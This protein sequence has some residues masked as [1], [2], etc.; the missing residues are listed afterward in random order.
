MAT[1]TIKGISVKIGADTSD[2]IKQLKKVDKEISYSEKQARELQKQLEFKFDEKT[3]LTAQAKVRDDLEATEQKAKAIKQQLKYLEDSGGIDS[4]GYKDLQVELEKNT[5]Q[6]MKL[7]AE[8][9][10]LDNIKFENAFKGIK[11]LSSNLET[12][13]KKTA[14]LSA[15]AIG[16]IA[17]ITKLAK[18]AVES[19]DQ[20][21]TTADQY[22]M[23]AEAIQ[24][25]NY[26]ALQTDVASEQLYKGVT[27]VRDA[28]GT[29]LVGETNTATEALKSLGVSFDSI[30]D[31]EDAFYQT[32][33]ALSEVKDS[34]LQAYYANEIFG[35]RIA[36]NLIP[37]LNQGSDGLRELGQE[38]E[39]VGYLSNEQVRKLA[40]F[41]NELNKFNTRIQNAKTELG[42][43]LLPILEKFVDI[44]EK[45]VIPAIQKLADWFDSLPE[46][47]Q[48]VITGGLMLFAALSPILF[49]I[50]K[51]SGVIPSFIKLLN[52]IK[53][54]GWKASLGMAALGGA[55]GLA[56]DLVAN[57]GEMSALEKVLKALALAA[58]VAAAAMTVFHASWSVG[59]AVGAITAGIVAGIA[60]IN[61]AAKDIGVDAN[62][63]DQ[64]SISDYA[65][66]NYSIPKDYSSGGYSSYTEDNSQYTINI[67]AD[68][69][70]NLEYDTKTLAD[71]VIKEIITKKQA[72]GR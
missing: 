57:W 60:A 49:I 61:A 29:A 18:G 62:F 22:S 70:G 32:V 53:D 65:N 31:G 34:T 66:Q 10:K 42:L 48:N 9:E 50:S 64:S 21:Q 40:D 30:S 3:F 71:S 68:L 63:K 33:I 51:I 2:F 39:A 52:G 25:W 72:S 12:A 38:F 23:S 16:A 11:T 27:K 26:I 58:L 69:T 46:P 44:L 24:K 8:L 35:E 1:E 17:G 19:G 20:I 5:T 45:N 37:L 28:I 6:A 47:M 36:T 67:N 14:I 13:A 56:F 59:L 54:A 55:I 4:K 43:A 7:N 41:D 15:S